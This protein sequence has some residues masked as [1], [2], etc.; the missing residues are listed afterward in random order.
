VLGSCMDG[1]I[2]KKPASDHLANV[3]VN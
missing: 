3:G 2:P 1:L